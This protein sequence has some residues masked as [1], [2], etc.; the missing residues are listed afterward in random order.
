MNGELPVAGLADEITTPGE[1]QVR[2]MLIFAGNPV[3]STPGGARLD[4]ALATLEWCVAVDMYVT[5]TTRHARRDPAAGLDARALRHRRRLAARLRA[6]PHPLQPGRGA[7]AEGRARGLADPHGADEPA[8]PRRRA[9]RRGGAR[10]APRRRSRHPSGSIDLGI[11]LGPHGILRRGPLK[12]LTVA[13]IK[14]AKHGIDLG[15]LRA[16]AAGRARHPDKRVRLA[17]PVLVEEAA[18]LDEHAREREAA[19]C[20]TATTSRSSAAASCAATT[21]GCTTARG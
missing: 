5:E 6:Q 7:Q 4:E 12:G 18:R 8:R 10:E 13:K 17:P 19:R 21:R 1:G 3:L 11:A 2:G 20:P 16:A 15:P 9:P 14:R